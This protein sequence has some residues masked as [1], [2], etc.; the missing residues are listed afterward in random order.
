MIFGLVAV[1][2]GESG[3]SALA[4]QV[5]ALQARDAQEGPSARHDQVR[6][7]IGELEE[8]SAQPDFSKLSKDRQEYLKGRLKELTAYQDYETKLEQIRDPKDARTDEQLDRIKANLVKLGIP[9]AYQTEWEGTAAQSR[10]TERLQDTKALAA[11]VAETSEM[12]RG[13]VQ[14]GQKVIETPAEANLP[15]RAE[16]VLRRAAAAPQPDRD[17]DKPIP[18]STRVCYASVFGFPELADLAT[19]RWKQVEE[20]LKPLVT[21]TKPD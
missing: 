21:P 16:A 13:L 17:R 6:T 9:P 18:G 2:R 20:R 3:A 4:S 15:A 14:D 1:F 11:A 10:H 8:L 19:R 5:D 7:R 12:Y